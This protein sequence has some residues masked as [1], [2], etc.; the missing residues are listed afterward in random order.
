[1]AIWQVQHLTLTFPLILGR[2]FAENRTKIRTKTA[3]RAAYFGSFRDKKPSNQK[4]RSKK[5]PK[6][7][8]Q[9]CLTSNFE[10]KSVKLLIFNFYGMNFDSRY[11]RAGQ[12]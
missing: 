7:M 9:S 5:P 2:F 1:M 11:N 3:P 6:F 8:I 10:A 12:A 4:Q